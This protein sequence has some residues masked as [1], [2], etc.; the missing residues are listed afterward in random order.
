MYFYVQYPKRPEEAVR[1]PLE[2]DGFEQ[3]CGCWELNI[4]E[5]KPVLLTAE[6]TFQLEKDTV[7]KL[8][9][10]ILDLGDGHGD[11]LCPLINFP[12]CVHEFVYY[13]LIFF[14]GRIMLCNPSWP[15]THCVDQ[16]V[17]E[18]AE[19]LLPLEITDVCHHTWLL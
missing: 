13:N 11:L 7:S 14:C 1:N 9:C 16:T 19:L 17:L 6:A 5:E 18:P 15:G 12:G 3:L 10:H 4:L 2:L 8:H